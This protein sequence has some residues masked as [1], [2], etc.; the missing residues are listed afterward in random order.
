MESNQ[1]VESSAPQP[2][3]QEPSPSAAA[4]V[5]PTSPPEQET[6]PNQ[7][8]FPA[9]L[10]ELIGR[11]IDRRFQSAKDKRWAQLEKQYGDLRELSVQ[12]ELPLPQPPA[13]KED[14]ALTEQVME[15]AEALLKRLGL[16]NT[17]EAAALLRD[18]ESLEGPDG[19]LELVDRVLDLALRDIAAPKAS[20]PSPA[21]VIAPGGGSP[22]NPDLAAVYRQRRKQIRPG[23]VNALTAL[24][25]EF[26][27]KG[28]N[29][30]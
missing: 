21:G 3:D 16:R 12:Q 13:S 2:E 29:I 5:E 9:E 17:P 25:R 14:S 20:A 6:N 18:Q 28:L 1:I 4:R 11:E 26:R 24:K 27:E 30:F 22:A 23:D 8:D 19:T 10:L 15:R 7:A